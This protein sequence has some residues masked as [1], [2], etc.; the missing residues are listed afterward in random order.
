MPL[1]RNKQLVDTLLAPLFA[2]QPDL[3]HGGKTMLTHERRQ[4]M[5]RALPEIAL[6]TKAH[7]QGDWHPLLEPSAQRA[8]KT[9]RNDPCPCGS[10]KKYKRC[11]GVAA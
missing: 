1:I 7:W 9:G 8:V 11:C 2:M 3:K 10:G 5:I 4:G 6:A